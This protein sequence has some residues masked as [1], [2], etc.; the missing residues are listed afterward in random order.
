MEYEVT[1]EYLARRYRESL[2]MA[3]R[4][5]D[6]GIARVHREFA[7]KYAQALDAAL[8]DREPNPAMPLPAESSDGGL[9]R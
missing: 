5:T 1:R 9:L 4:A 2:A 3:E 6:P 7:A 8:L